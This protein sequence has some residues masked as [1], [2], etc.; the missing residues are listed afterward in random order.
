MTLV[1]SAR[2]SSEG[3]SGGAVLGGAAQRVQFPHAAPPR[4]QISACR[5]KVRPRDK[6]TVKVQS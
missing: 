1:E 6:A 2:G 5:G 3:N 4:L